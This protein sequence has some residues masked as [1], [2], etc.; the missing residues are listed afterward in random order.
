MQ[1]LKVKKINKDVE[2]PLMKTDGSAGIDFYMPCDETV[3][4]IGVAKIPLGIAVEVPQGYVLLLVPRSS[5]GVKTPLRIPNSVGVIDSDYR[6]EICA[7]FENRSNN[8]FRINKG[9]RMLQGILL[10]VPQTTIQEVEQLS[11][12]ERGDGGFG[13]T[14]K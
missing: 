14:G 13:S 8:I 12:T 4:P 11:E 2:L 3:P 5:T 9:D 7:L 6:G 1:V 10:K